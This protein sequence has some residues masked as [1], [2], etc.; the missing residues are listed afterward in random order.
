MIVNQLF[1]TC[2]LVDEDLEMAAK[3]LPLCD[4]Y[5]TIT[6]SNLLHISNFPS[7]LSDHE[8]I[9]HVNS[10]PLV[11]KFLTTLIHTHAKK[12]AE[13]IGIPYNNIDFRPFGFFS[14]MRKHAYLR[15]HMHRDCTFSG[16]FYLEVDDD[17]PP[18]IFYDPRQISSVVDSC[19]HTL[20]FQP[21]AG[22]ILL[23]SSWLEHEIPQK[24]TDSSR[25]VF[26]FNI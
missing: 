2:V 13:S 6:D 8:L 15:K 7:T 23:W 1:P 24:L 18:L 14:S 22:T 12:L 11:H 4:K 9:P 17:A 16:T 3:L 25:K 20:T 21:K 10:E 19:P 26:S 5:T